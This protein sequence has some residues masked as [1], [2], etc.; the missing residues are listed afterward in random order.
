GVLFWMVSRCCFMG[1]T[2]VPGIFT[3]DYHFYN[4]AEL[5]G[6]YRLG[7]DKVMCNV[8]SVGQSRD[9]NTQASYVLFDGNHIT[10]RRAAYDFTAMR[11]K[12]KAVRELDF[13]MGK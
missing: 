8:G 5:G 2:H 13:S 4:P 7:R 6:S 1:H 9:G 12:V 10:F 11:K 3:H